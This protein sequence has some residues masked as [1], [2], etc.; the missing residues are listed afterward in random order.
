MYKRFLRD[1]ALLLA[2]VPYSSPS[3]MAEPASAAPSSCSNS[4]SQAW[5]K[6]GAVRKKGTWAMLRLPP[7]PR[8]PFPAPPASAS[9]PGAALGSRAAAPVCPAPAC[10]QWHAPP[11]PSCSHR[12]TRGQR[13][14]RAPCRRAWRC[15]RGSGRLSAA[16]AC[17]S[18]A[19]LV[20]TRRRQAPTTS[21]PRRWPRRPCHGLLVPGRVAGEKARHRVDQ[22][23]AARLPTASRPT[24]KASNVGG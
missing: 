14:G 17:A 9:R 2:L 22:A 10:A 3:D 11:P 20:E 13:S 7:D 4:L 15:P 18:H 19:G 6:M 5:Q 12:G 23:W 24:M 1:R 16:L 8:A 21:M